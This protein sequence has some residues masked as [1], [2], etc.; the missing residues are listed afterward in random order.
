MVASLNYGACVGGGASGIMTFKVGLFEKG[1]A[2]S[3]VDLLAKIII[4]L[5]PPPTHAP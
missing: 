2:I 3:N 5:A 4:P 1:P